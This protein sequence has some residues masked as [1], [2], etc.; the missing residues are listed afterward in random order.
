MAID[1]LW[2]SSRLRD[3]HGAPLPTKRHGR[4][5]RWRVR[6]PGLPVLSF[7]RKA[8]AEKVDTSRRA[9]L[10]QAS[11]TGV[12]PRS[13]L[14]VGVDLEAGFDPRG[15]FVY[16]LWGADDTTPLYVGQSSN[17]LARLGTHLADTMKRAVIERVT[18][19]RC[20]SR[21]HMD[22]TELRLIRHY[23]PPW[24]IAGVDR[25]PVDLPEVELAPPA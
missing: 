13:E 4:G 1:D 8:D 20:K 14:V 21:K 22:R 15:C 3:E 6:N 23:R 19:V 11:L 9:E 12:R 10:L 7:E 17:V 2:Y 18:M 16:L 25:L 5:K 24:N